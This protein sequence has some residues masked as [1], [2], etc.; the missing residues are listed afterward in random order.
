MEEEGEGEEG[1]GT[2]RQRNR[3]RK[4]GKGRSNARGFSVLLLSCLRSK[5]LIKDA[6]MD[7]DFLKHLDAGQV[8]EIVDSMYPQEFP[9]GSWVIREGDVGE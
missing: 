3:E 1:K 2:K 9:A 5:Q 4:E 6:V 7:N 8:R